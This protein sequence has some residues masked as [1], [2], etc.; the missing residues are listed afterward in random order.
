MRVALVHDWL[1]GMRGG[2]LC[3]EALCRIFP[4][5]PIFTLLYLKGTVSKTIASHDIRP[6]WLQ[7][8]PGVKRWYRRYLPL[9]PA[10]IESHDLRGFDLIVSSA[11]RQAAARCPSRRSAR[12]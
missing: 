4:D 11:P 3:L 1:T 6:S 7:R 5:A 10:A 8:M 9:F 2:E 12:C